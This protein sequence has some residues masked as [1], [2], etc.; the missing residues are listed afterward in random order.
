MIPVDL[1][2][3]RVRIGLTQSEAAAL[4]GVDRVTWARWEGGTRQ[5]SEVTW[6]YWCHVA[7]L[8]RIPFRARKA[9]D[10]G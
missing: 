8:E 10:G 5:M 9:L 6:R 3:A 7:G 1:R 2:A 4:I